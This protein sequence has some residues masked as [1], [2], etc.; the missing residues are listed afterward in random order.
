MAPFLSLFGA[1]ALL[2]LGV[3]ALCPRPLA[4]AKPRVPMMRRFASGAEDD[5][6]TGMYTELPDSFEDALEEMVE[7]VSNAMG[8]GSMSVTVEFDTSAGDATYTTLKNSVP[9][10]QALLNGVSQSLGLVVPPK[11][12][13]SP[14]DSKGT[15]VVFFPDEGAAALA[16]Q[17]WKLTKPKKAKKSAA[18]DADAEAE[19]EEEDTGPLVPP[20]V[21]VKGLPRLV[22]DT[23]IGKSILAES[24]RAVLLVCP[25]A[26]DLDSL[27]SLYRASQERGM[28]VIMMNPS[29]IDMGTTGFGYA[30]RLVRERL[31]ENF[32][33]SYQL[34][35]TQWGCLTRR[36]GR[37]FT[38]WVIDDSPAGQAAGGYRKL[39]TRGSRISETE[40]EETLEEEAMEAGDGDAGG[41]G[42][43]GKEF[44]KFVRGF[45]RL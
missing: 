10:S 8:L 21:R 39:L 20:C 30:G 13:G 26:E 23:M 5:G 43:F 44:A 32:D 4:R 1:L 36:F 16:R 24:D 15:V 2:N 19:E 27:E 11:E 29:L 45:G 14:G 9:I 40:V 6:G 35:T 17:D 22:G 7:S 42:G 34:R 3:E 37:D 18:A 31:I 28:P 41:I 25:R 33:I 12:D 38:A